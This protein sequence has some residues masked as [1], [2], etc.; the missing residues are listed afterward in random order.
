MISVSF[1]WDYINYYY[2][3]SEEANQQRKAGF[4]LKLKVV[5]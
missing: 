4:Y 1:C 2:E 5:T 3:K